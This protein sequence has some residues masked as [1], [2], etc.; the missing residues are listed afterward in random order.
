MCHNSQILAI[1]PSA[2]SL[3]DL[4]KRVFRIVTDKQTKRL[5]LQLYDWIGPSGSHQWKSRIRETLTL[6]K[7]VY[8]NIVSKIETKNLILGWNTSL[9][10]GLNAG[11]S[12]RDLRDDPQVQCGASPCLLGSLRGRSG[13]ECGIDPRVQSGRPL[14]F[15]GSMQGQS[16]S[17][18]RNTS[19]F[20]R[21]H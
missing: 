14:H 20:L 8:K 3:H 15:W 11:Q 18:I 19:L 5:I 12:W 21:F 4:R 17:P 6:L 2:R 1:C 7:C 13:T 16:M 9:F 10:I